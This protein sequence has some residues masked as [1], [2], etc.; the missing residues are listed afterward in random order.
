M[1]EHTGFTLVHGGCHTAACWRHVIGRLAAPALAVELDGRPGRPADLRRVT[2]ADWVATVVRPVDEAPFQRVI[3]VGHS[4]AGLI[5][6][7]AAARRPNRITHV[8]FM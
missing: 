4:M 8:V 7:E 1:D 6:A 2:R 5:L 3:L